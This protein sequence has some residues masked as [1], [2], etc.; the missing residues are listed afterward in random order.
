MR[1][2]Y[3]LGMIGCPLAAILS[4]LHATG[5]LTWTWSP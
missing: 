2:V 1:A 3:L 5:H 4:V